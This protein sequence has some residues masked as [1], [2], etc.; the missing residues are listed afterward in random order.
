MSNLLEKASIITTPTAYSEGFLHSVKPEQTLGS[1]LIT[2]GDF[3]TDSD[4]TLQTGWSISDGKLRASNVSAANAVQNQAFT[5]GVTY[6]ITYTV[7]DYVKG[8]VRA[9]LVGGGSG[10]DLTKN[11]DRKSV[12]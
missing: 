9:R 2:N 12:V 10:G 11:S 1:E 6:K 7:S 4:W 5:Q 3:A 8:E